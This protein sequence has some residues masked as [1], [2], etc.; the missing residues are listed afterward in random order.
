MDRVL[1]AFLPQKEEQNGWVSSEQGAIRSW[2][3]DAQWPSDTAELQA[4][5]LHSL[6][7]LLVSLYNEPSLVCRSL[8]E[9]WSE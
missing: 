1:A 4:G 9:Y 8:H 7:A 6:S 5:G 2:V 3:Q